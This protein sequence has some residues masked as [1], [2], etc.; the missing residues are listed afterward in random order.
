MADA[1]PLPRHVIRLA[2]LSQRRD[3]QALIEPNA[4]ARAAVARQL[5]IPGIR[6]L[7][8]AATLT[9]EGASG[10]RLT[11]ELGAT[12][13]Q[14]CVVTLE[15]VVTRIDETVTR[16]Y[17]PGLSEPEGSE[18]EMPED[19]TVEP[20]PA[21]IDIAQVMI[22]ALALALPDYPRAPEAGSGDVAV[23]EPGVEPLRD[24]DLKPFAGLKGLRDK[25]GGGDETPQ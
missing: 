23:S 22:E 9:P 19:D 20:L 1:A 16:R 5:D 10:W 8:F 17:M 12:V 3:S 7:R 15:P 24:A 18:V 2:E 25:L 21:A 4:G 6:K 14:E 11:G 13:V